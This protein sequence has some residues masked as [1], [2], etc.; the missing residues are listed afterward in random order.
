MGLRLSSLTSAPSGG[1]SSDIFFVML[2]SDFR[3]MKPILL[4]KLDTVSAR[5]GGI[6]T[7]ESATTLI[8][9]SISQTITYTFPTTSE[10]NIFN[11]LTNVIAVK[12][13]FVPTPI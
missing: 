3:R 12:L 2:Q 13:L 9:S 4:R 8:G 5:L 10:R 6:Y 7:S 11:E 1:L